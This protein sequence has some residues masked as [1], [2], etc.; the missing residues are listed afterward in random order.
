MKTKVT[1]TILRREDYGL[2]FRR[3]YAVVPGYGEIADIISVSKWAE[4][5]KAAAV[6]AKPARAARRKA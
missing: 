3:E 4:A 1:K 2:L 6:K 5:A